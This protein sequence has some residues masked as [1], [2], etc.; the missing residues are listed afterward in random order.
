M[1]ARAENWVPICA[2]ME[3]ETGS[4]CPAIDYLEI[5]GARLPDAHGMRDHI[6]E[7]RKE[8]EDI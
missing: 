4:L 2:S 3:S 1:D 6:Y 5:G 8:L 7:C